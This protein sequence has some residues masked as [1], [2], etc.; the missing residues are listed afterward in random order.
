MTGYRPMTLA[1]LAEH[2]PGVGAGGGVTMARGA[3][4]AQA[5][6]ERAF[7]A[8]GKCL[9]RRDVVAGVFVVGCCDD[10]SL[11]CHACARDAS[12]LSVSHGIGEWRVI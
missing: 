8:L 3:L 1:D 5:E 6:L 7:P 2:L 4:L 10:S 12:S 11:R 9:V